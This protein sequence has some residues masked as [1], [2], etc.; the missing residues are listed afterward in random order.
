LSQSLLQKI[1]EDAGYDQAKQRKY[2]ILKQRYEIL[3]ECFKQKKYAE[4]FEPLPFN[5]GYFMCV[6]IK[7]GLSA[8]KIRQHLLEKY[9]TGVI[10]F[11]NVI[12]LA[13]SAISGAKIPELVENLYT[14]CKD[15]DQ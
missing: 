3:K 2:R 13:F 14:A 7:K 8:E 1:Y 12:R 10:V 5:S 11:G 4:Y 6:D 15:L 9:S